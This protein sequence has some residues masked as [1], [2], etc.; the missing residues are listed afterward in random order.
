MNSR[1]SWIVA[2]GAV[3]AYV[4]AV[5]QRTSLGVAAV[6][7]TERFE[8]TAAAVASL[9]V[10]QI[11]IYAALQLPIGVLLDRISPKTLLLIG[12]FTMASAQLLLA[13]APSFG[14]AV[15]ARALVGAGDACVFI[16]VLRLLPM[17]FS[18]RVLPHLTQ[19]ISVIGQA[20]QLLSAVPLVAL[21]TTAGWTPSFLVASAASLLTILVVLAMVRVRGRDDAGAAAEPV[22]VRLRRSLG[23]PGT[24]LA[25]WTHL[26]AASVPNAIIVMW[27]YP[28]L[29]AGLG[30][31][32]SL[33]ASILVLVVLAMVCSGPVLGLLSERL[34]VRRVALVVVTVVVIYAPW[35]ALL[36]WP[37]DPPIVL[38][39]IAFVTAGIGG[40]AS[41]MA[42]DFARAANPIGDL[43]TA[44]GFANIGGFVGGLLVMLA[45][46][47]ILDL[48]GEST[49]VVYAP[50]A[51]RVALTSIPAMGLLGVTGVLLSSLRM[52]RARTRGE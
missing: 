47:V 23:R 35:V 3:F 40:P 20:G 46:G 17:W 30:Y 6:D 27:G 12:A 11:G 4:V 43:G 36:I 34:A 18:G 2:T 38:V 22:I 13:L 37:W 1:R 5:M 50:E 44:S 45:I 42:F 39:G 19:W 51:F 24:Q 28:L 16:S 15:L 10:T 41:M 49:D 32:P 29:T 33:A 48:A 9:G 52:R 31:A 8:V 26:A 7:A 14:F 25:F 21:L